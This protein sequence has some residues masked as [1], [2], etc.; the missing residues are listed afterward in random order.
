MALLSRKTSYDRNRIMQNAARA[1]EKGKSKK[2]LSLYRRVLEIEPENSDLH[3]K[4]APL[5][6][7]TKQLSEA[8][9]SYMRAVSALVRE[10]F[11]EQATGLYRE[12]LNY[13]PRDVDLWAALADLQI[14]R[15]Q[16]PDAVKTL[17]DGR[18]HF[19]GRQ[20]RPHAIRLLLRACEVEPH[21][22]DATVDLAGLLAKSPGGRRRA[23]DLLERLAAR[24]RGGR[25]RRI[26]GRQFWLAPGFRSA[27]R[28]LRA[29]VKGR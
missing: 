8:K 10:G 29:L 5:F 11:A 27:G 15:R 13:M 25:L 2:A 21:H 1:R 26:R 7:Q 20:N 24:T 22:F 17:L 3:R 16:Q 14:K 18:R 9:S 28:W 12:A 6:A 4:V 19:R 23:F